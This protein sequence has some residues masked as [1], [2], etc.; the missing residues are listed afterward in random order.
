MREGAAVDNAFES[1][2]W[3]AAGKHHIGGG[4]FGLLGLALVKI[5][6]IFLTSGGRGHADFSKSGK[7]LVVV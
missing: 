2:C 5:S 1:Y 6:R 3:C 7:D 4:D